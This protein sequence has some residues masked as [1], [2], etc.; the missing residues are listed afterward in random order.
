MTAHYHYIPKI[1]RI[2]LCSK[3]KQQHVV[4]SGEEPA[5]RDDR[6]SEMKVNSRYVH[7]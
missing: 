3:Q 1:H 5:S 7:A 2:M 4:V 6:V